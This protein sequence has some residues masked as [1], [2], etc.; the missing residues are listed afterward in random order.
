MPRRILL[1]QT[2]FLGDVVLT[3][4]LDRRL[5]SAFPGAE[6]TWMVRPDAAPIV[7]PLLG[8]E[9][10]LV[11]DKRGADRGLRGIARTAGRLRECGFDAAIAVQRSLRTAFVLRRAGIPRI[12]GFAGSPGAWLYHRRVPVAGAHARD[13]LVALADGLDA[14]PA[15]PPLPQLVVD[16]EAAASARARLAAAGVAGDASL[17]VLAPGSA[18]ETKRW[19]ARRFGEA[20]A[21]LLEDVAEFAVVVGGAADGVLA[22][23]LRE[24]APGREDSILD[25]TGRTS[26]PELIALIAAAR[27]VV[28]NDSAP[29]HIASA[30]GT[31]MVSLFGPTVP[32]QGFA[33]LGDTA[34]VVERS[35]L[36]CRPCSRH[37]GR[38]CPIG[39]H[40]CLE[41]L[42]A[43]Q[44]V[45]AARVLLGVPAR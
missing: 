34:V 33:P 8:S 43:A 20:A 16:P 12:A 40:E 25:W 38:R 30:T 22:S 5:R 28:G 2:S 9:H 31:P 24:A 10:V 41:D 45:D 42:S 32:A 27:L 23:A 11:Y 39:T 6:I 7:A 14:P 29:G 4:A 36:A 44:V 35:A 37:G 15:E 19:P 18:W 26:I 17:L 13:R 1:V 3:T 21:A